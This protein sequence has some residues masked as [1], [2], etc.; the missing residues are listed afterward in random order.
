MA[1]GVCEVGLRTC[2]KKLECGVPRAVR[3]SV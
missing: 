1:D 2:P 3:N